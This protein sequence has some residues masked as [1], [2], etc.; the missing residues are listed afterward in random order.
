MYT[1]SPPF[2]TTFSLVFFLELLKDMCICFYFAPF[3]HSTKEQFYD[4]E[5][6]INFFM[7]SPPFFTLLY[8]VIYSLYFFY[9]FIL[10]CTNCFRFMS[11]LFKKI[12][13]AFPYFCLHRRKAAWG[14]NHTS[15]Q[16]VFIRVLFFSLN[17]PFHF[18][19]IFTKPWTKGKHARTTTLRTFD[20]FPSNV[21]L[22]NVLHR[23]TILSLFIKDFYN[24]FIIFTHVCQFLRYYFL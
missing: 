2:T 23:F 19:D 10:S 12:L 16:K 8:F 21:E 4:V 20:V 6:G 15:N 3:L 14:W 9:C 7:N 24:V 1:V 17:A 13:F 22:V 18:S 11:L 5:R